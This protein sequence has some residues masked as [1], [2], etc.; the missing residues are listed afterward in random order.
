M[1]VGSCSH[2]RIY[3]L[4]ETLLELFLKHLRGKGEEEEQKVL[5]MKDKDGNTALH[6]A[7]KVR[8][9]VLRQCGD[10]MD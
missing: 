6:H 4:R 10:C 1:G 3:I 9:A 8:A 7:A 5:N 2:R